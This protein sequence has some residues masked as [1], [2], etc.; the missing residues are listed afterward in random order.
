MKTIVIASALILFT[1]N[2]LH[3]QGILDRI[4]NKINV[5]INIGTDTKTNKVEDSDTGGVNQFVMPNI[6]GFGGNKN[7]KVEKEYNFQTEYIIDMYSVKI[8]AKKKDKDSFNMNMSMLYQ[9]TGLQFGSIIHYTSVSEETKDMKMITN[10]QDSC[11]TTLMQTGTN[12]IGMSISLK[13]KMSEEAEKN[14][15]KLSKTGKTKKILGKTCYEYVGENSKQKQTFWVA[16]GDIKIWEEYMQNG[17]SNVQKSDFKGVNFN[18]KGMPYESIIEDKE[19]KT[20]VYMFVREIK[21]NQ[22][23]KISTEGYMFY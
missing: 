20:T 12:K 15:I 8:D 18:G 9:K 7:C 2:A 14:K 3:S 23:I 19:E 17:M 22:N 4:N 1:N 11:V 5:N 21:Q 13:G 6:G 16:E 10:M